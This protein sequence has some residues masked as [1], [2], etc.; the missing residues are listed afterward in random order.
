VTGRPLAPQ[1]RGLWF[2]QQLRPASSE[3]NLQIALRLRGHLEIGSLHNALQFLV[4]RHEPLRTKIVPDG[5]GV[6]RQHVSPA[7]PLRLVPEQAHGAVDTDILAEEV[8]KPFD[9]A[10]EWP[11]RVR[12]VELGTDDHLLVM[13]FNHLAM[14]GV[15]LSIVEAELAQAYAALV[16]GSAV[17]LPPLEIGFSDYAQLLADRGVDEADLDFWRT[18]LDGVGDLELPA[19]RSGHGVGASM[20]TIRREIAPETVRGLREVAR[21]IGT[22]LFAVALSSYAVLLHRCG[23]QT[24]FAI[25]LP[26]AGRTDAVCQPLVGCFL[27]TVC[28]RFRIDP[29]RSV[30]Q[31]ARQTGEALARTLEHQ[32]VPFGEVVRALRPGRTNDRNPLFSAFCSVLDGAAPTFD[33]AGLESEVVVP[34]YPVARFDLNATFAL[35]LDQPTVQL[36]FSDA[37]FEPATAHRLADRLAR[38][39]DWVAADPTL[40]VAD[41]PLVGRTER[42]EVLDLINGRAGG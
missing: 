30:S 22:S 39:L 19:D 42:S 5:A 3:Y 21:G 36:E 35:G 16:A 14:D 9:L 8:G 11:M 27:N 24:D 4:L 1:Q 28:V 38:V 32:S 37:L 29:A 41:V 7:I 17:E 13:T 2:L 25:G 33:F 26:V 18:E 31:L 15:S 6:P 10:T 34:E 40:R 12:L 23:G 20:I